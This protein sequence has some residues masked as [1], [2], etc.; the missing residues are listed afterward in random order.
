[1]INIFISQPMG[2]MTEEEIKLRRRATVFC[3]KL[4]KLE[5]YHRI[6]TIFKVD[7]N[8]DPIIY[9][10]ESIKKM[11][12]ADVVFFAKGWQMYRGCRVEHEVALAY[13]KEIIY[14]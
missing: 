1:M 13:G 9:L 7:P 5:P 12:D 2:G 10:G 14:E 6:D 4:V 11:A 3:P 8:I